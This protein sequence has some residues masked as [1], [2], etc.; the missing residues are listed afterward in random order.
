MYWKLS[1]SLHESGAGCICSR[2]PNKVFAV[3]APEI[4]PEEPIL[5]RMA[6]TTPA[7]LRSGYCSASRRSS[8]GSTKLPPPFAH[9]VGNQ[10]TQ[11]STS[12]T[13]LNTPLLIPRWSYGNDLEK[14]LSFCLPGPA[15]FVS[16]GRGL[17][18]IPSKRREA[19]KKKKIGYPIFIF[20]LLTSL[21][22][23]E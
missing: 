21:C 14:P 10:I 2:R 13:V 4:D 17:P 9:A 11:P 7:Q 22:A 5:P 20:F 1:L 18:P 19:K 8:S 15:L 12:S 23:G 6:R 16:T 3:A